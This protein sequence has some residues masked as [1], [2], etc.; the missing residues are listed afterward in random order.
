VETALIGLAGGLL[1]LGLTAIGLAV[2]RAL[3]APGARNVALDVLTRLDTGMLAITLTVAVASTLC[4]GLY[5][6]WRASRVQ[7]AWQLKVP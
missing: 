2:D 1:G 6:T 3:L 4:A 7:P 5:P